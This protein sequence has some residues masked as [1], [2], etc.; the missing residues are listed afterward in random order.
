MLLSDRAVTPVPAAPEPLPAGR[1]TGHPVP[2]ADSAYWTFYAEV[3]AA[4]VAAWLPDAAVR[5]LDLS[6]GSGFAGQLVA[7]GHEVVHVRGDDGDGP[8]TVPGPGRLLPVVADTR[9]LGWLRPDSV[10]LVL[11]ESR[12]L[13]MCLAAEVTV[14]HL[15]RVLRPGGRLL[16]VVDSL[17]LGLARLA[18]QGR[19]AELADVPSADVVLVPDEDGSI[20]RCFW[21]EELHQL[22]TDVGLDVEWVRPRSVLT[23]ATVERALAEGGRAAL[24]TLVRTEVALAVEREGESA[25]LHLVVSARRP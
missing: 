20:T 25:G 8:N 19:W 5:A 13:S 23:P 2:P 3:A 7:R 22:L 1:T 24:R 15:C 14:E 11:A 9:S 16:L 4:Q 18:D 12:A 17:V 6:G 10:D 21:P